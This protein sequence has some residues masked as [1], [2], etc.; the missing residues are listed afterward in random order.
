MAKVTF[1]EGVH[2]RVEFK[3][4]QASMTPEQFKREKS[5]LD[6]YVAAIKRH[7]DDVLS[8]TI[9][10][11]RI[12]FCEHCWNTWEV[13]DKYSIEVWRDTYPDFIDAGLPLCCATAQDEWVAM[14]TKAK[15]DTEATS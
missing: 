11:E 7:V 15:D 5:W 13:V 6:D 2:V 10:Y 1:Y 8:A 12:D 9:E 4:R 14:R 3:G